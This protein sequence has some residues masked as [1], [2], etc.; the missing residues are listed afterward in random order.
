MDFLRRLSEI[1]RVIIDSNK[2]TCDDRH[3]RCRFRAFDV[4]SLSVCVQ[5]NGN[6]CVSCNIFFSFVDLLLWKIRM[7]AIDGMGRQAGLL[8]NTLHA[9]APEKFPPHGAPLPENHWW[10]GLDIEV[11]CFCLRKL[12]SDFCPHIEY[13]MEPTCEALIG[14]F[15]EH[16]EAIG[17]PLKNTTCEE[18]LDGYFKAEGKKITCLLDAKSDPTVLDFNYADRVEIEHPLDADATVTVYAGGRKNTPVDDI[19]GEFVQ[20]GIVGLPGTVAWQGAAFGNRRAGLT[21]P[22]AKKM[23][24]STPSPSPPAGS[25]ASGSALSQVLLKRAEAKKK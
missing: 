25:S 10:D 8:A 20:A 13:E 17:A 19:R 11:C 23:R 24:A 5:C 21:S 6:V 3:T 7:W 18:I 2:I 22:P 16:H 4:N 12:K 15:Q 14:A 9:L 1:M